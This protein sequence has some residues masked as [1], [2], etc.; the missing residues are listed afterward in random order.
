MEIFPLSILWL[1]T[2]A[3]IKV[4]FPEPDGPTIPTVLLPEMFKVISSR[5]FKFDFLT[6]ILETSTCTLQI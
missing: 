3:R 4:V 1:P 5:I 2:K 6:N